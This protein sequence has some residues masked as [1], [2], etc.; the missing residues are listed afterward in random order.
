[1]RFLPTGNQALLVDLGPD[2]GTRAPTATA[3]GHTGHPPLAPRPH[4]AH[5]YQALTST[6]PPGAHE[7]I[8]AARTI[9]IRYDPAQTTAATLAEHISKTAATL[10][11]PTPGEPEPAEPAAIL[12][13]P[14]R[15]DGPDLD[16]VA[17]ATGLTTAEVTTRHRDTLYTVAFCGFAPGF[18]YLTGLDET[19]WLPRR[20][21]PRTRVP[22]GSLAIA[23]RYTAVY[24]HPSPGGWHLLGHTD[25]PVW[26]PARQPPA[27]LTPGTQVRFL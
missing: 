17:R 16:D 27:L 13:I 7:F 10:A 5:L 11:D 2:P 21:N 12:E 1:M 24:P 23:D 8:P 4:P 18:G 14:I 25:T 9:L 3:T 15:Y 19:L 6:P 22:A 20:P 26:D